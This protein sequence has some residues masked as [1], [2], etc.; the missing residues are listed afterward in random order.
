ME[1]GVGEGGGGG[2]GCWGL[3]CWGLGGGVGGLG[4]GGGS[5]LPK[6]ALSH[7]LVLCLDDTKFH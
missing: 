2:G 1:G 6:L 5:S 3:G 7:P 4:L